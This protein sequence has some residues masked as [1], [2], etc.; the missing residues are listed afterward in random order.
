[1]DNGP[2]SKTKITKPKPKQSI[3]TPA[4]IFLTPQ[5]THIN[6][7]WLNKFGKIISTSWTMFSELEA[8][9]K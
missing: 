4:Y 6:S 5:K 2:M 8:S 1:M 3:G 7:I 9:M